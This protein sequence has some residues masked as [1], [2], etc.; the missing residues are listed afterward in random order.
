[1]LHPVIIL[2]SEQKTYHVIVFYSERSGERAQG[3]GTGAGN[4]SALDIA[5]RSYTEPSLRC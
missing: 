4:P 5:D 2:H 1:M 3:S